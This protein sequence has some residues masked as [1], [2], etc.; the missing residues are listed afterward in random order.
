MVLDVMDVDRMVAVNNLKPVTS[1]LFFDEN[2]TP[3]RTGLFSYELFGLPGSYERKQRPAYIQLD[4]PYLHPHVYKI[5]ISVDRKIEELVNGSEY[6]T[7]NEQTKYFEKAIIESPEMGTGIDFLYKHWDGLIFR[8]G[9]SRKRSER[10][11]LIRT[12]KRDEAFM[13]K[14]II[15]PAFLRDMSFDTMSSSDINGYYKKIISSVNM[16]NSMGKSSFSYNITKSIIQKTI[17]EI[18][19]YFKD[20][21]RLKNGFMHKAVMGKNIDYGVRT[22]ISAPSFNANSW[23][24]LPADFTHA[25]VPLTQ[26]ISMFTIHTQAW[27]N[28]WIESKVMGRTNLLVYDMKTKTVTRKDLDPNWKNDFSPDAIIKKINLYI[29]TPDSRF[30]PVNIKFADGTYAPFS[31]ISD[32]RD[33][34]LESGDVDVSKLSNV[35]YFTWTDLF[36][37]ASHDI[38]ADKHIVITRYPITGHHSEYFA[39]INVRSTFK[40]MKMLIGDTMYDR[41]PIVRF[42][43][44]AQK[45]ESLFID[46]LEVF[47]PYI[48]PLGADHDGDQVT[49]R[50]L[51]TKEAND[52]A[53][54][55]LRSLANMLGINGRS[56]RKQEDVAT[57]AMY[58]LLRNPDQK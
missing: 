50:A 11:D 35:R 36:Y 49:A 16:I 5:L 39:G 56:V 7:Y 4:G 58:N 28:S 38:T 23:E 22:L 43:V 51:Y 31:F 37:I 54:A 10:L 45:I 52:F 18:Y 33:L 40:T 14:Q 48:G 15:I 20:L 13:D 9:D 2:G 25:S 19:E 3:D 30:Y 17:N 44:E 55:Y 29:S 1:V 32:N 12:L 57:H 8:E 24:E 34:L 41:Y 6:F 47:P 46:S 21:I 42:D 26:C 53:H 27:I